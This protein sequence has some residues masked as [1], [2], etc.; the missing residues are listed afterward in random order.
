MKDPN[1]KF[2]AEK[3][4]P[5]VGKTFKITDASGKS[6]EMELAELN[7][8]I[9]KGI[10]CES[11]AAVFKGEESQVCEQG[12]Y[13]VAHDDV[14]SFQLMISPNSTTECEVVVSRLTG[15]AADALEN[16]NHRFNAKNLKPLVGELFKM[17][18]ESGKAEE[19]KLS[20]INED[21]VKGIECESFVAVFNGEKGQISEQGLYHVEHKAVGAYEMMVSPN[22]PT[23]CE[24]VITRLKGEPDEI[25]KE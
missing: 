14:G 2:N 22:S 20:E 24:I 17:T 11:F 23:E 19:V 21:V 15:D 18:D 5:L 8:D 13:H 1:A 25:I 6:S 3:L 7:E 16:P 9:V 12:L 4:K 10:E